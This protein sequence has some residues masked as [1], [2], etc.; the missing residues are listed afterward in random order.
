M[1]AMFTNCVS[2]GVHQVPLYNP[3]SCVVKEQ[4]RFRPTAA[5]VRVDGTVTPLVTA[6]V[7]LWCRREADSCPV[8]LLC[9]LGAARGGRYDGTKGAKFTRAPAHFRVRTQ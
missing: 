6:S 5:D 8:G 9:T 4:D 7:G 1:Q 2:A 3:L